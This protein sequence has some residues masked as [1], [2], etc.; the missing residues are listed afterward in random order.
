MTL[1]EITSSADNNNTVSYLAFF[2]LDRTITGKISGKELARHAWRTGQMSFASLLKALTISLAYRLKLRNP[3]KIAGEMVG[4]TK[5]MPVETMEKLSV[6]VFHDL[7]LPSV[8]SEVIPEI[9]FHKEKNARVIILSSSISPLCKK[10][11]DH[12]NVDGIICSE[13]EV[14]NGVYTGRS[15]GSLCFGKEKVERLKEYCMTNNADTHDAWYY[16]DSFSDLPVLSI[17]GNPVCVNPDRRLLR[18]ALAN[19]W[20]VCYWNR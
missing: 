17:V 7:L 15:H 8:H 6:E 10:I 19:Q 11:A 1:M 13:L 9:K 5:D 20:K 3:L 4:W 2:D 16:G 14:V 18:Q 12:L